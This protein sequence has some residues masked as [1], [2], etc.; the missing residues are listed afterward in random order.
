MRLG[1][2]TLNAQRL[3]LPKQKTAPHEEEAVPVR[4]ALRPF[5]ASL[6]RH[7]PDQVPRVVPTVLETLSRSRLPQ[8][9]I[10]LSSDCQSEGAHGTL[11]PANCSSVMAHRQLACSLPAAGLP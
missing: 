9:T 8:Q 5:S 11:I 10:I 4:Y 7:Y 6:R 1:F 3:T 2:S